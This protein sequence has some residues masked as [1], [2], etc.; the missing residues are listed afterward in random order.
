MISRKTKSQDLL[1][2]T[3]ARSIEQQIAK[4]VLK[5]GDKLPSIRV[6]CR[7]H[8]VSMGTAQSA[9]H[10][11]EKKSLIESRP[12]SGFYVSNSFKRKLE[13]PAT[14][15]PDNKINPGTPTGTFGNGY[16]QEIRK[17]TILFSRGAPAPELLPIAK[18]N[19]SVVKAIRELPGSGTTYESSEGN[20]NLRRQIAKWSFSWKGNLS[21]KDILTTSGCINAISHCLMAL[22]QRG[23]SIAVESPCFYGILQLAQSLGLKV[24]EL[25]TS[26]QT[27]IDLDAL[28]STVAKRKIT[29]CLFVSNFS[30]PLGSLMPDE[31]KKE[32]VKLLQ[33]YNIPLIEDDLYGD[34]YFG[35]NRPAC[36]KSFDES[37]M[38]LL[39]N[40][41]SKTLAPGYRVGWVA[42]GRFYDQ[43]SRIKSLNSLYCTTIT[44]EVIASF[45]ENGRYEAHLRKL[46]HTLH[47]N[48]LQFVRVINQ[49]FPEGTKIGRPQ[50]GLSLWVE[51]APHIDTGELY[52]AALSSKISISPGNLF[53]LQRQFT[54]HMRLSYGMQWSDSVEKGLQLLGKLTKSL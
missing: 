12:Q 15:R 17:G 49:H 44:H 33:Q 42:P 39:C 36:C 52:H 31:H 2:L 16:A 46:R 27:G 34:L 19:K 48:Y 13:M 5:V 41:V 10:E 32:A 8:G 35:N 21:E 22:T 28:R 24:I 6:V 40:S 11:L 50:G 9:Y 18:L 26:P 37:G 29:L 20:D 30:N 45:L 53:T 38:V 3:I 7:Q 14:S 25:P 23:D 43:V 47:T 51:L 4:E 1:Y 54:H